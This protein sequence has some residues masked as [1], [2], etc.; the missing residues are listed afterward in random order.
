MPQAS[1]LFVGIDNGAVEIHG[2]HMKKL[3]HDN[4]FII[5]KLIIKQKAD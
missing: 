4:G 3:T 5:E 2:V 1:F